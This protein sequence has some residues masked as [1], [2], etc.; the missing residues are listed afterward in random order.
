MQTTMQWQIIDELV[1]FLMK[2]PYSLL[3]IPLVWIVLMFV[4][5]R[6]VHIHISPWVVLITLVVSVGIVIGLILLFL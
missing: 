2:Y 5:Q 3:L 6:L 4:L 1:H